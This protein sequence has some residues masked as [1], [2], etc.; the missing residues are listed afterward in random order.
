L[1]RK[2]IYRATKNEEVIRSNKKSV[3]YLGF[4]KQLIYIWWAV[5]AKQTE[6]PNNDHEQ[7]LIFF[8]ETEQK[9]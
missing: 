1:F 9:Y 7:S 8:G 3:E 4:V 5:R 2:G 6:K